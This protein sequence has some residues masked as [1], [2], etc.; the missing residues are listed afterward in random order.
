MD[1]FV[2]DSFIRIPFQGSFNPE[3]TAL[4]PILR[5]VWAQRPRRLGCL[6]PWGP[7]APE[8]TS[9]RDP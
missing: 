7:G 4:T 3:V 6:E 1:S 5:L 8:R 9:F 2:R